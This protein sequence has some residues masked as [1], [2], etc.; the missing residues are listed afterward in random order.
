MT[1]GPGP[2]ESGIDSL[3]VEAVAEQFD[4]DAVILIDVR[5]PNEYIYEHIPGAMLFP[6]AFF[7]AHKLPCQVSKRI[8]FHCG[9][10]PR[11]RMIAERCIAAGVTPVAFMDGGFMAWKAAGLPFITVNPSTGAFVR[12][13]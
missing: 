11:S 9:A 3:S 2:D 13:P 7:D 1:T 12:K 8:V 4:R 6:M 5:T 10:G